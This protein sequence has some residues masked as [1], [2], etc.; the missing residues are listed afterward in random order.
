[1]LNL[2]EIPLTQPEEDGSV[3][4]RIAAD[5]V[6]LMWLEGLSVL[7]VPDLV[8]Q[9]AVLQEDLSAVPVLRLA[10]QVAATLQQQDALARWC[11]LVRKRPAARTGT[12]DDDVVVL[13]GHGIP[14]PR[15]GLVR[16][17]VRTFQPPSAGAGNGRRAVQRPA[18]A[19]P[20]GSTA[21][22]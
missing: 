14:F 6:L 21:T 19:A 20:S 17:L 4:L 3:E 2:A 22:S 8:R 9:V 5:E 16:A 13:G 7:V 15:W 11:Q 1:M 10:R 12:D 18:S